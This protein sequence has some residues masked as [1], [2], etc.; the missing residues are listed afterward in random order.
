MKTITYSGVVDKERNP[1]SIPS[2]CKEGIPEGSGRQMQPTS[3]E[4]FQRILENGGRIADVLEPH[5]EKYAAFQAIRWGYAKVEG[6]VIIPTQKWINL[7]NLDGKLHQSNSKFIKS[8]LTVE[9][10]KKS[11]S[12]PWDFGNKVL[13]N[14]CA[15]NFDHQYSEKVL[16]KVWLIGRA[17]S[18]AI[19]RRKIKEVDNDDFYLKKV[20][21]AFLKSDIDLYLYDLKQYSELTL[22]VLPKVLK[23]HQYVTNLT[24]SITDL[25]KRSFSSKYLHFHLPHL[26]FIYDSRVV[27]AL[28]NFISRVPKPMD[29]MLLSNEIDQEYAKYVCKCYL[30]RAEINHQFNI[31]LTT[32]QLDNILIDVANSKAT[33]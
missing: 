3:I 33:S 27:G 23:A 5:Y 7:T 19:E 8:L 10:I 9:N 25:E 14:L 20:I 32:R 15:D 16:S 2:W 31:S 21:P 6:D 13:Y 11:L 28:R 22:E 30:L 12:S 26:F 17:Y 4:N 18:A 24:A 1:F 29:E